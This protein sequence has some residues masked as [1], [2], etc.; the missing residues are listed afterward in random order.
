MFL[1]CIL[2]GMTLT[3]CIHDPF[4]RWYNRAIL[5][6]QP[7]REKQEWHNSTVGGVASTAI[8]V[9]KFSNEMMKKKKAS[10][11]SSKDGVAVNVA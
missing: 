5:K 2:V 6:R 1:A 7:P 8:L 10:T 3:V 11:G 4:G 9:N